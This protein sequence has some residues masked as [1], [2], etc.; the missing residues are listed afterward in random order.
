MSKIVWAKIPLEAEFTAWRQKSRIADQINLATEM[1]W[2]RVSFISL[3]KS[4]PGLILENRK[5]RN[6]NEY[7]SVGTKS[8]LPTIISM[9]RYRGDS[10]T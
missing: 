3:R 7:N 5:R 6:T 9:R 2:T 1:L 4:S 10:G 8:L